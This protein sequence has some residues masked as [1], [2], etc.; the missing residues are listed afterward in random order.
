MPG[1]VAGDAMQQRNF[2]L[3]DAS[4]H[5]AAKQIVDLAEKCRIR[6]HFHTYDQLGLVINLRIVLAV[7][8]Q[9]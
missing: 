7:Y 6:C 4:P 2:F 3:T 1:A 8:Y 5:H 9:C